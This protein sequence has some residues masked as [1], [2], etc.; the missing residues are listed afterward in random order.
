MNGSSKALLVIVFP[1]NQINMLFKFVKDLVFECEKNVTLFILFP[2]TLKMFSNF[3]FDM[4]H[5]RSMQMGQWADL[6]RTT[7]RVAKWI[8]SI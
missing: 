4:I 7:L 1:F 3:L 8:Y 5:D 6:T 2:S